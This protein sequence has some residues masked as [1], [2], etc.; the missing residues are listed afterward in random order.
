MLE[1][2]EGTGE[3]AGYQQFL[4]FP[5]Y[6]QENSYVMVDNAQDFVVKV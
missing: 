6:F 5:Q 4:L 1:N 2:I 3:S